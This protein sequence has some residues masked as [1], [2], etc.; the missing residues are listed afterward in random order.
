MMTSKNST[1]LCSKNMYANTS[2]QYVLNPQTQSLPDG[3]SR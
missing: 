1:V 2:A 3:T